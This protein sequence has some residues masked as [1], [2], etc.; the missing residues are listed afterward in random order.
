MRDNGM[1]QVYDLTGK[2]ISQHP[3]VSESDNLRIEVGHLPAGMYII[4]LH[5]GD[6]TYATKRFVKLSE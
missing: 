2:P 5:F 1:L 4:R 3:L 6:N